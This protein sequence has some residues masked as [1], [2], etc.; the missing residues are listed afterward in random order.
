MSRKLRNSDTQSA[1]QATRGSR[2]SHAVVS[3]P[4]KIHSLYNVLCIIAVRY[5]SRVS[6]YRAVEY[7]PRLVIARRAGEHDLPLKIMHHMIHLSYKRTLYIVCYRMKGGADGDEVWIFPDE[8]S[9]I[10]TLDL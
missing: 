5:N 8:S 6:L 9:I 2:A 3:F 10:F 4:C 7:L 1:G